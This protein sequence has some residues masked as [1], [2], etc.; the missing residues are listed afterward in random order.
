MPASD[1]FG[2]ITRFLRL[3]STNGEQ[4]HLDA[5]LAMILAMATENGYSPADVQAKTVLVMPGQSA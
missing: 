3:Y 4:R 1:Y 2:E 5:A